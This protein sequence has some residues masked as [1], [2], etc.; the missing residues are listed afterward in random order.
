MKGHLL[1]KFHELM[2][3]AVQFFRTHA[4]EKPRH[5]VIRLFVGAPLLW[6]VL[7][8]SYGQAPGM[9]I[10]VAWSTAAALFVLPLLLLLAELMTP[11]SSS[12]RHHLG[13][14]VDIGA[15]SGVLLLGGA[16]ASPLWLAYLWIVEQNGRRFGRRSLHLSAML[17]L[18]GFSLVL[19]G[20]AY[21]AE[22]MPLGASL[23]V[24]LAV[25]TPYLSR[26]L[27]SSNFK[28]PRRDAT[29]QYDN[30]QTG[31]LPA[32]RTATS[33]PDRV[34][35]ARLRA[36]S[37]KKIL[38]ISNDSGEQ[39]TIK[40]H[41]DSWGAAT[42]IYPNAA[43]C[44]AALIGALESNDPFHALIAVHGQFDM[45][46]RQLAASIRSEPALQG[47]FLIHVGVT[48]EGQLSDQLRAAGYAKLLAKPLDKT[49]LF[50]AIYGMGAAPLGDA[51]GVVRLM[52]HYTGRK[53][54]QPLS[55]LLAD[56]NPNDLRRC[57]R[58][59]Q[60]AGHHVFVVENGLRILDA[61]ESHRFDVAVV[62]MHLPQVTGLEAFKLYRFTRTDQPWMPF[63]M[64]LD[65]VTTAKVRECEDAGVNAILAKPVASSQL[66][67][68]LE[69]T[70]QASIKD[71][72]GQGN[73]GTG[74]KLTRAIVID[75]LTLDGQR[76]KELEQLGKGEVFLADLID[77]FIKESIQIL[78]QMEQ[79]VEHSDVKRFHDLGHT[80][81]DSAG[82]LGTLDLYQLGVRATRLYAS[83]FPDSALR[84]L[85][86]LQQCC[87]D[88]HKALRHYLS[89]RNKFFTLNE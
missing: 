14:L 32:T 47:L 27:S 28:P 23:L 5:S 21:W 84:L 36:L 61:L 78:Q 22:N 48:P 73:G 81:K 24:M 52:D 64:L 56:S 3:T 51:P 19:L 89:S 7:F 62:A 86:D 77:N 71:R 46:T 44:F 70:V 18:I 6:L 9:S 68:V 33:P 17:S 76:L 37:G 57:K 58:V 42:R 29:P 69:N 41:L 67:E 43:R 34:D 16:L 31:E 55:I 1:S 40:R 65:H 30:P 66:T 20:N 4:G 79:A 50:D 80:I 10:T 75:G 74:A 53:R 12:V 88:S 85:E 72:L 45:D 13:M 54:Q 87:R 35:S 26:R 49:L 63:I 2:Q 15:I 39:Q 25:I 59:L 82:S 8:A 83:D 11:G 60:Q 38:L